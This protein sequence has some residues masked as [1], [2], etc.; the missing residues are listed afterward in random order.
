MSLNTEIYMR[1]T[2]F[3]SAIFFASLFLS[4]CSSDDNN[5]NSIRYVDGVCIK[6]IG[7]DEIYK[8]CVVSSIS[9]TTKEDCE[10]DG[11]EYA[12]EC[13]EKA[14]VECPYTSQGIS[15]IEYFYWTTD[16]VKAN[17]PVSN[18]PPCHEGKV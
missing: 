17:P 15:F 18:T 13:P 10:E 5:G 12:K 16:E 11:G 2:L 7:R 8:K 3:L 9:Y 4:A 6:E 1:M 14:D